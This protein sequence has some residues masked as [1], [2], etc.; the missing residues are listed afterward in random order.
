M[1]LSPQEMALRATEGPQ[2]TVRADVLF[3]YVLPST[4]SSQEW[5]SVVMTLPTVRISC[6]S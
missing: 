2:W 6:S 4:T 1:L 5:E 3:S